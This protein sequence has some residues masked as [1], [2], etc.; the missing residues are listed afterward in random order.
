M[1][2]GD[3]IEI[4]QDPISA[5]RLWRTVISQAMSDASSEKKYHRVSV[6][7]W[8]LSKDFE[9]VCDLASLQPEAV[10]QIIAR[11]LAETPTR[12][13]EISKRLI[14]IIENL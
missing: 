11:L 3:S 1:S 8:L 2:T 9:R 4:I 14:S 7:T 5:L 13:Q 10:R 6:A 12:S